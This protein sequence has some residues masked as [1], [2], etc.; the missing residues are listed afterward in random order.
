MAEHT[1]RPFLLQ[2]ATTGLWQPWPSRFLTA[3]AACVSPCLLPPPAAHCG[4][5]PFLLHDEQ[6]RNALADAGFLYD[7][8]IPDN[9]PSNISPSQEQRGWP[10]RMDQGIPQTCDT[11]EAWAGWSVT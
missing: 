8:S 1:A 3:A 2:C 5:A 7:S 4:R 11:G 9:V 6:G 10:Y